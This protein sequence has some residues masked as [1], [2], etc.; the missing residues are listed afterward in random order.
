MDGEWA[1]STIPTVCY[2]GVGDALL[3][4]DDD[5]F[6]VAVWIARCGAALWVAGTGDGGVSDEEIEI[7]REVAHEDGGLSVSWSL[8]RI[9]RFGAD[10]L[11][12]GAGPLFDGVGFAN[13]G[14]RR[15]RVAE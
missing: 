3:H 10:R 15:G 7:G 1:G 5:L 2:D 11:P 14:T 4:I 6:V 9:D 13:I 12:V 8:E